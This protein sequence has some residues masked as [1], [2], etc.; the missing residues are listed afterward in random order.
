MRLATT[1]GAMLRETL[2]ALLVLAIAFLNFGH[3]SAVFAAGGRVVVTGHAICGDQS[4]P[5]A[6]DH[7][8]CH[9]CRPDAL[10]LPPAPGEA[11]PVVFAATPLTYDAAGCARPIAGPATAAQP[12]GPPTV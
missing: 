9:A 2:L 1:S 4:A 6:G 11:A 5:G 3:D 10:A 12:R 8:T 7:F